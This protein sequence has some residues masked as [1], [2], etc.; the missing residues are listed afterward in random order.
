MT[1]Y[2]HRV[3]GLYPSQDLAQEA[4]GLMIDKGLPSPQIRVLT[5]SAM[6]A[7]AVAGADAKADSDDVLKDLLRDG[8][9]STAVGTAAAAGVSIALAAANL[10]LFIASPVLGALYLL[11]WGASLGGLVGAVVGAERSKGDVS[12]L[13]KDALSNG[14][15]VLVAH[16]RTEAEAGIA[17]QVV[18][19]PIAPT[20]TPLQHD[21]R[22]AAVPVT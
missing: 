20:A 18:S 12:T 22:M 10:T 13:I 6:G 2:L 14:Q 3:V 9:I 8:A 7:V 21:V 15:V 5:A 19:Q 16:A 17:Q 1:P 11:G 4:R